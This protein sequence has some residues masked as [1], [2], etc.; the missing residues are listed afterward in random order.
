M[1]VLEFLKQFIVAPGDVGAVTPSSRVLAE[2]MVAKAQVSRA[3]FVVELGPGTGAITKVICSHLP[4]A[5]RFVALEINEEFIKILRERHP[6]IHVIRDSAVNLQ[7]R[8]LEQGADSCD[9]IVSGLPFASFDEKLQDDILAEVLRV[10]EPRGRFI[11]FA[12]LQGAVLPKGRAI[13]RKLAE[14]F[15]HVEMSSIIWRNFPPAQ[16]FS[17]IK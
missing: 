6:G 8:L 11:T 15:S 2:V 10:L 7:K 9:A 16:V 12:Y 1:V 14:R 17:A 5:A 4:E 13:R 3:T